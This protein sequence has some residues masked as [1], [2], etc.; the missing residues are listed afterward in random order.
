M[1]MMY[2]RF[3]GRR[4]PACA[5]VECDPTYVRSLISVSDSPHLPSPDSL[6]DHSWESGMLSSKLEKS[7]RLC[8]CR[9][10]K[11]RPMFAHFSDWLKRKGG[12]NWHGQQV[13]HKREWPAPEPA[14]QLFGQPA[15]RHQPSKEPHCGLQ[16]L[17]FTC[18][19]LP[20]AGPLG[21]DA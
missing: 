6:N 13:Y 15:P 14:Y 2:E 3:R 17:A 5:S 16:P 8:A 9:R 21:L 1:P 12:Q 19:E 11:A 10:H 20:G 18:Q 7:R 4:V